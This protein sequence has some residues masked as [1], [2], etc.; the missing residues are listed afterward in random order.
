MKLATILPPALVVVGISLVAYD[1]HQLS[2]R[3]DNALAKSDQ[4]QGSVR[5]IVAQGNGRAPIIQVVS[6][7]SA[8]APEVA[9]ERNLPD[10]GPPPSVGVAAVEQPPADLTQS[11]YM[12]FARDRL[13]AEPY[14]AVWAPGAKREVE[15]LLSG[16]GNEGSTPGRVSCASTMCEVEVS[17]RDRSAEVAF[18][19]AVGSPQVRWPGGV[20]VDRSTTGT[21]EAPVSRLIVMREG[22]PPPAWSL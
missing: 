18:Q 7:P 11:E 3:I 22:L 9:T 8:A 5:D 16:L 17:H 12:D 19:L 13:S 14:D 15:Q 21:A 4:L 6:V 2:I 1:R 20:L 10:D